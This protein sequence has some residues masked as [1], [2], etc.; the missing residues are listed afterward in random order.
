MEVKTLSYIDLINNFWNLDFE[1][2]FSL[3]QTR[4]YF[5]LLNYANNRHWKEAISL[6]NTR[7]QQEVVCSETGLKEARMQLVK[8]GMI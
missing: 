7:L 6:S 8:R 1:K 2:R 4:Y 5:L 3:I